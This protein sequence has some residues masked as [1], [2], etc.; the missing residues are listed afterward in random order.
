MISRQRYSLVSAVWGRPE[1]WTGTTTAPR[2]AMQPACDGRIDAG[3][4]KG[5]DLAGAALGQS[6][7]TPLGAGVH[8]DATLD[9]E[10]M[11]LCIAALHEDLLIRERLAKHLADLTVQI[12]RGKLVVGIRPLG[13]DLEG[14][15][16]H[17]TREGPESPPSRTRAARDWYETRA[18]RGR[19]RG[20]S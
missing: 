4:E 20:R 3:R 11:N 5:H 6:A 13:H 16:G 15:E 17:R 1:K 10:H 12:H 8:V 19:H 14:I 9:D 18:R 7:H 2:R